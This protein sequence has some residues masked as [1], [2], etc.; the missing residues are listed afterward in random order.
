MKPLHGQ[1]KSPF[2]LNQVSHVP[3]GVNSCCNV[4][5]I[6]IQS[7]GYDTEMDQT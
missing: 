2:I 3:S 1:F 6:E 4:D 7:I 5:N